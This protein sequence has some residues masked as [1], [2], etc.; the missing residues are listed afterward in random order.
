MRDQLVVERPSL[1]T[2]AELLHI[3]A[4][5]ADAPECHALLG[6]RLVH[7]PGRTIYRRS[8][9]WAGTLVT[10]VSNA[11]FGD[12]GNNLFAA[13]VGAPFSRSTSRLLGSKNWTQDAAIGIRQGPC[14]P[15]KRRQGCIVDAK[16]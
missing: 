1:V 14:K 9:E 3:L 10:K 11:T 15:T 7:H 16:R 12:H 4:Y 6:M 8:D 5:V 2:S 13:Q